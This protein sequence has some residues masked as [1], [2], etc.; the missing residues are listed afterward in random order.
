MV[1]VLVG[2]LF[3]RWSVVGF[4]FGRWSV[5]NFGLVG[6]RWFL[7]SVRA[8]VGGRCFAFLLVG[9]RFL[10]LRMVGGRWLVVGG[11]WSV[12]G[13]WAV[14]LYYAVIFW[15]RPRMLSNEHSYPNLYRVPPP[16]PPP[17]RRTAER[18][19]HLNPHACIHTRKILFSP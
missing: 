14:V 2:V 16:S 5:V 10:F 1:G 3:G 17:P 19:K 11:L 13:R 12:T 8:V 7:W 18:I 15:G 9:G 6:G 4:P